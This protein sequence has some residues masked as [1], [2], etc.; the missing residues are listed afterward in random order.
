MKHV[1]AREAPTPRALRNRPGRMWQAC[2]VREGATPYRHRGR[3]RAPYIGFGGFGAFELP[4]RLLNQ[5]YST[6]GFF[7]SPYVLCQM[8]EQALVV[9]LTICKCMVVKRNVREWHVFRKNYL[10]HDVSRVAFRWDLV[11]VASG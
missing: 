11:H 8:V 6:Y 10:L 1:G 4:T 5:T 9:R 3:C 7:I 2:W